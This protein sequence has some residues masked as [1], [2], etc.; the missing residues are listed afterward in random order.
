[1]KQ[2]KTYIARLDTFGEALNSAYKSMQSNENIVYK[3]K[4]SDLDFVDN[5]L[6]AAQQSLKKNPFKPSEQERE[7][8]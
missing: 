8:L 2:N 6:S 7:P 4:E 5:F 3:D 1:M